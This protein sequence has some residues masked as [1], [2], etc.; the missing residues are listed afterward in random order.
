MRGIKRLTSIAMATGML[1]VSMGTQAAF[2][3]QGDRAFGGTMACGGNHFNRLGGTEG[4]YTRYVLRNYGN[5]PI[6][7]EQMTVY[8]ADGSV[9]FSGNGATLPTFVNGVLGTG[10]NVLNPNET[11]LLRSEDFLAPLPNNMRPISMKIDWAAD[12]ETLIPDFVWVRIS[13]AREKI[14]ISDPGG[15]PG[16]GGIGGGDPGGGG[17]GSISFKKRETRARHLNNCRSI[18]DN[19]GRHHDDDDDHDDKDDDDHKKHDKDD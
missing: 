5:D 17:I 18:S 16:G 15:D 13:L 10:D 9:L 6:R 11:A 4:N 7:I 3:D 8:A 14:I 12:N 2:S 1:M 19:K